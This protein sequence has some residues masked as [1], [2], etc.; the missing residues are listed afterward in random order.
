MTRMYVCAYVCSASAQERT[1]PHSCVRSA[2]LSLES[3]SVVVLDCVSVRI[4]CLPSRCAFS[5]LFRTTTFVFCCT[6]T[7]VLPF[8]GL[9][10]RVF[11]SGRRTP[12]SASN[13]RRYM[14]DG[15]RDS[16]V[17]TCALEGVL[18]SRRVLVRDDSAYDGVYACDCIKHD[19]PDCFCVFN[20]FQERR[21][22][23]SS[24][25]QVSMD[26]ALTGDR[27]S[28]I[29]RHRSR[30]TLMLTLWSSIFLR[31]LSV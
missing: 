24:S 31:R 27:F 11:L 13:F 8:P 9:R 10:R 21:G 7:R 23:K 22:Q 15:I 12:R 29:L 25:A 20:L 18:T 4:K 17:M 6:G 30:H 3:P 19:A 5:W 26:V 1:C 2:L 28:I 16:S 14:R